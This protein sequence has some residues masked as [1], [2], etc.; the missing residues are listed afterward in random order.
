MN[1]IARWNPFKATARFDPV[2]TMDDFLRG[3]TG[4]SLLGD[5]GAPDIRI[6]VNEDDK[7]YRVK[8]EIPGVDKKD[9]D[10]SIDGNQV[11]ISAEVKRESKKKEG[12]KEVYS[13]RYY[14]KAYR[15]FTLPG[16]LDSAKAEAH[17]EAGVLTLT[18]PKKQNG[19]S[20]KIAVG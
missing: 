14:G 4:R 8:A 9:V 16:D 5:A 19:S 15:S 10:V 12:E 18:L 11:S 3:V 2:A 20:R 1:Q 7:A 13:E 6:E 17:C